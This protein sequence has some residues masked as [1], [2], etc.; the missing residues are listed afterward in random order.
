MV[1]FLWDKIKSLNKCEA[2]HL[3]WL[4]YYMKVAN[5]LDVTAQTLK[6]S[7]TSLLKWRKVVLNLLLKSLDYVCDFFLL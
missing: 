4:L 2:K 5:T 6:C 3:L 1:D 7:K